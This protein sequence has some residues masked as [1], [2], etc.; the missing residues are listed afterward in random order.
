MASYSDPQAAAAA[1][2]AMALLNTQM[3]GLIGAIGGALVQ[4]L[5]DSS[6]ASVRRKREGVCMGIGMAVAC[7]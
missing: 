1:V 6:A 2:A 7:C 5:M 3:I 4:C